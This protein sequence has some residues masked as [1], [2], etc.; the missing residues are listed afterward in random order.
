[1]PR[2]FFDRYSLLTLTVFVFLVPVVLVGTK[3]ALDSNKNN[4]E[5]WLPPEFPEVQTYKRFQEHFPG[6]QFVLISWDGCT[7]D[8][9]RLEML[10]FRLSEQASPLLRLDDRVEAGAPRFVSVVTGNDLLDQLTSPPLNLERAEA[11]RR[12]EDFLIGVDHATTC[13]VITLSKAGLLDLR[14]TIG[15]INRVA[16]NDCGIGRE[17][18]HM[19]GPPVDNLAID[20]EG[21][22]TLLRLAGLSAIVGLAVSWWCLRSARLIAVVF[23]ASVFSAGVSLAIVAFTGSAMNAVIFTMPSLVYIMCMSGAI[24]IVN[25]YRDAVVDEGI[26]GAPWRALLHAWRPCGLASVT[27]AVGLGSLYLSDI[28][29]IKMFGIYSAAGILAT[30]P[31]QFLFIPSALAL[32]PVRAFERTRRTAQMADVSTDVGPSEGL[33]APDHFGRSE[34]FWGWVSAVVVRRHRMVGTACLAA[35]LLLAAGLS[36]VTTNVSLMK[37]FS[38]GADIVQDYAWLEDKLGP[39]VPMEVLL[40]FDEQCELDTVGRMQ[41]ARDV[42]EQITER[43]EVGSAISAATFANQLDDGDAPPKPRG[44]LARVFRPLIKPE[45]VR[46]DVLNKR[47]NE[48]RDEYRDYLAT[49]D[50]EELYR[51][52]ARVTSKDVDYGTFDRELRAAVEPLVVAQREAGVE[53]VSVSYTG[54]VPV[55]YKTQRELLKGLFN[56]TV[57]AFVLI[58]GVMVVML[59]SFAAGLLAM[60]PNLFP[61]LVIFGLMGWLDVAIDIGTMMTA[62]VALGVAVDDTIHYLTW[63]REGLQEGLTPRGAVRAAYGRCANAM[64][65][66]TLIG[67]LGLAVF[68]FSSF[69]P[70]QRFG[71]LMITL[72]AAALVGDLL[73]LP[74]MLSSKV[75]RFFCGRLQPQAADV[76]DSLQAGAEIRPAHRTRAATILRRDRR[77]RSIKT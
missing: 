74:A 9:P 67:G 70:T 52:S 44:T 33:V 3:R 26:D 27:T 66:T 37:L 49:N 57:L 15:E 62:S 28:I 75:A 55:V 45:R 11:F 5:E 76:A 69:T 68:A 20:I 39:L 51:V 23:T 61:V 1:M 65:Q 34:R 13:A 18:I 42:Q 54:L 73:L 2:S 60:L 38:P 14:G 46:R 71:Y 47:L 31:I 41:L 72:M 25:Y 63:F 24:H 12:L 8:D 59:R 64:L 30:L 10:D 43:P 19:G 36:R 40:H 21:E 6:E 77:H 32:W 56:S 16:L 48:H 53:G 29:P 7:L 58:A 22:K 17:A 50:G 35:M 4:V